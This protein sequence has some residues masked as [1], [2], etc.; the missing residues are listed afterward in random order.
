MVG[1]VSSG[2][3][4]SGCAARAWAPLYS[5]SLSLKSEQPASTAS[6]RTASRRSNVMECVPLI[7]A[8]GFAQRRGERV[9][10]RGG[11]WRERKADALRDAAH[12]VQGPLHGDGVGFE[13]QV[14]V[15]A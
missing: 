3:T 9:V 10:V 4:S 5:A 8:A 6:E 2:G 15:Q 1:A 7:D 14:L 12:A 11:E 13:E